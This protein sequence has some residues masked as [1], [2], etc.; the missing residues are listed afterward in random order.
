MIEISNLSKRFGQVHALDDVSWTA[1]PGRVTGLLGPNGSGK[2][3]TL[4]ILLG[5]VAPTSGGA[6]VASHDYCD[7]P[8][9]ARTVGAALESSGFK[10]GRT[11]TNHLRWLSAAQGLPDSRVPAVVELV[12]LSHVARRKVGS[13]SLGMRQRLALAAAMLGDPAILILDEP[14]NGLDPEGIAW[15]RGFLRHL[16][17]EGRTVVISSHVLS[18]VQQTVDDVVIVDRGRLVTSGPLGELLGSGGR[19]RLETPEPIAVANALRSQGATVS[20][21]GRA[22]DGSGSME[23]SGIDRRDVARIALSIGIPLYQL[24]DVRPELEEAFLHLTNGSAGP[25]HPNITNATMPD[26]LAHLSGGTQS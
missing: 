6:K 26:P 3:T 16:S 20:F 5:L 15:L 7:I 17:S 1:S 9:R 18:E 22:T 14:A 25:Q 24:S 19:V 13:F 8:D 2:T 10:S 4:R 23:V 11:A 21:G 12:G